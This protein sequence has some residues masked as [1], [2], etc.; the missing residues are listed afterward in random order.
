[1]SSACGRVSLNVVRLTSC[2]E[3]GSETMRILPGVK[4]L[5]AMVYTHRTVCRCSVVSA[6]SLAACTASINAVNDNTPSMAAIFNPFVSDC[7][8]LQRESV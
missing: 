2:L 3:A 5:C 7:F 1:M 4:Y 8:G 6:M